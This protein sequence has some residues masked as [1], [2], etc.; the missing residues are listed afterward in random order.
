MMSVYTQKVNRFLHNSLR[1]KPN[2]IEDPFLSKLEDR[3]Y[4]MGDYIRQRYGQQTYND[5]LNHVHSNWK[6]GCYNKKWDVLR[7]YYL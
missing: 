7:P 3:I 6:K 4:T 2:K 5:I 1:G